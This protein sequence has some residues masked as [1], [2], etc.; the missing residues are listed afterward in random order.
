MTCPYC[1]DVEFHRG[2]ARTA[3]GSDVEAFE[4][5]HSSP[6]G[7]KPGSRVDSFLDDHIVFIHIGG[8]NV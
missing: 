5:H 4:R 8:P 1:G 7:P 2:S 6:D 3:N